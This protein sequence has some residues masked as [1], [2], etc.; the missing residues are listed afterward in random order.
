MAKELNKVDVTFSIDGA[1]YYLVELTLTQQFNSHHTFVAT[2]DYEEVDNKWMESPGQVIQLIGKDVNIEMKHKNGNGLNLF[3]GIVTNVSFV[4]Q[5]G[6]QNYIQINGCSPTIRLDGN[7]T[8]DSFTDKPLKS[9][10]NEAVANSGNG[11]SINSIP[12]F[13]GTVDYICQYDETAFEFLNRL[14]WLYGE[15]FFYDGIKC[16]FG[17]PSLSKSEVVTYDTEMET[18]NLSANLLP[19]GMNR[20][21]YLVHDDK[22]ISRPHPSNVSGV[23]GYHQ[24]SQNRSDSIYTSSAQ[25]PLEGVVR[26]AKEMEDLIKRE[27]SRNVAEMLIMSGTTQTSK[28]KIGGVVTIRLPE[29]MQTSKKEVGSFLITEVVHEYTQKGE[30]QN[31]FKGIPAEME[32]I[33]M[34]PVRHPKADFQLA[35]VK[36]NADEKGRVR[37][38]F[39]WQKESGKTTNWIRVQ[40][41]DAGSSM[42]VPKNRGF[43][44]IPEEGDQ[45]MIGFEYGDPNR[46]FVTGSMFPE[47]KGEGGYADNMQK[48]IITRSG[49]KIV[50]NDNEKSLHLEDPSG[51]TIHMDGK[52]NITM[53]AP[54][55]IRFI[56]KNIYATAEENITLSAGEDILESAGKNMSGSAGET[57]TVQ[58]KNKNVLVQEN[59]YTDVKKDNTHLI[60]G[61][62]IMKI[63]ENVQV[64]GSR[65]ILDVVDTDLFVKATGKITMKSGD[66]ID[67]AQ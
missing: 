43:V 54:E 63:E 6:Q 51:N 38:Q 61:R 5:H 64:S 48:S 66:I 28:I 55:N 37:V 16:H 32:Y 15:C 23:S 50:Y 21:H 18:F 26:N 10:V 35:T 27:K 13:N 45:V 1:P 24:A 34:R 3:S 57:H 8:M 2:I 36:S 59:T 22:E 20:Y 9:I 47:T 60:G 31:R 14:S 58:A 56:A 30:Y 46:P 7:K 29:N 33:P 39:Q 65:M 40:T 25:L 49:I 44:F 4:G 11:A 17:K 19:S 12:A 67:I 53:Q 52:G 41:P 62:S 42:D